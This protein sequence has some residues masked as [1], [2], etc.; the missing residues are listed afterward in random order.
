ML[1]FRLVA[2]IICS[3]W[4]VGLAQPNNQDCAGAIPI[5]QNVYT[6]LNSYS[7]SGNIPSEITSGLSCLGAGELN[8]VWY[9]FTVQQPGN[10][11]FT[12]TPNDPFDDYDW[13]VY[14]LT[15]ASCTD[16]ATNQSLEV[17]CNFSG[18][19]G[20]NGLTGPNGA[21]NGPCAGQ[22]ESCF[23][24]LTNQTYVVNV[25]NF[26]SSQ[27]GYT[28]DFG[29]STAVI[30]DNVPP[31]I[32]NIVGLPL[33]C[34]ATNTL[35]MN[36]SEN[37]LC[38]TVQPTDFQ[39]VGPNGMIHTVTAATGAGCA[40]GGAQE[41]TYT[42]TFTP[43]I[44]SGGVHQMQLIGPVT[45]LCGNVAPNGSLPFSIGIAVA[46]AGPDLIIC[47]NATDTIGLPVA[48]PGYTYQWSPTQGA[49]GPTNAPE[50]V[51]GAMSNTTPTSITYTL[52]ATDAI[53]C[54]GTDQVTVNFSAQFPAAFAGNDIH[55][56]A[57]GSAQIGPTAQ[58]GY[59]YQ[60][61]PSAGA[62]GSTTLSK[63][64]VGQLGNATPVVTDYI[65][66]V[67][68]VNNCPGTDTVQVQFVPFPPVGFSL[69]DSLCVG[70]EGIVLADTT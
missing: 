40:L 66:S 25:S 22:N 52:T 67:L 21:N 12:I 24:V 47:A 14:N 59:T 27:S 64:Q 57:D 46:N 54:V 10:V 15:S 68:D 49:V 29:A 16:I 36:F 48:A 37:V 1:M 3:A 2:G 4:V 60:W 62:I 69:P 34:N 31:T 26:S 61:G 6:Q 51:V 42:L 33:P 53:G 20:C 65:L 56:C 55:V 50:L 39:V 63:L 19:I 70:E 45:D 38:N 8:A 43:A 41:K 32:S 5:C 58:A 13:A 17:R 28:I 7:G 23:P 18:N 35:T 9:T 11:C 44:T 30:F